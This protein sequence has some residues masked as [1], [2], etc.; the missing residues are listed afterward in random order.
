MMAALRCPRL[1]AQMKQLA[2]MRGLM[3]KPVGRDHRDADHLELQ[4]RPDRARVLQLDPRRPQGP[5]RYRAEDREL[6]LPDPPSG[7]RGPGCIIIEE[8]CGT[9]RGLTMRAVVDGGEVI[10]PLGERILGRTASSDIVDPADG[11]VIVKPGT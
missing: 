6:G 11:N 5:G 9:A 4:G 10:E 7:R 8:D 1:A 2:G 3:A